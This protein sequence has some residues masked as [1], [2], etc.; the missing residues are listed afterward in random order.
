MRPIP[1]LLIGDA[2]QLEFSG[3]ARDLGG[4]PD[5]RPCRRLDT[6]RRL[7]ESGEFAPELM[8]ALQS[9]PGEFAEAEL[10]QL[11]QA[12]PLARLV[13]VYGAWCEGKLRSGRPTTGRLEIAAHRWPQ[14]WALQQ[15]R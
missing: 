6:A 5:T 1:I 15:D 10:A 12:A 2:T 4:R 8:I 13:I 3:V 11:Q 14:W 9:L 7:L